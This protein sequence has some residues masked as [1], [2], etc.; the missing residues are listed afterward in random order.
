MKLFSRDSDI[1]AHIVDFIDASVESAEIATWLAALEE[2]PEHMR[3]IR[4]AEIK[5][6]MEYDRAPQQH[7]EIIDLLNDPGILQAMNKVVGDVRKSGM[8]AKKFI[9]TKDPASFN[10]LIS[11]ISA[12]NG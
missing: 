6:R 1:Y 5:T 3:M 7:V 12:A 10:V 11:L 4:L 2:E 9:K 8:L